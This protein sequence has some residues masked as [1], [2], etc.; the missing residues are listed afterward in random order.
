MQRSSVQFRVPARSLPFCDFP[1][2]PGS[3]PKGTGS[4]SCREG[5][6]FRS[7]LGSGFPPRDVDPS[8]HWTTTLGRSHK[9]TR[10]ATSRSHR[11]T[12]HLPAPLGIHIGKES[13]GS[14]MARAVQ[15]RS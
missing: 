12:G 3:M 7:I 10:G 4:L 5:F 2:D 14:N 6:P 11:A 15:E 1:F 8:L 9:R 13:L